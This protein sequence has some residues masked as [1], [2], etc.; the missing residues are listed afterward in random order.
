[1]RCLCP[2]GVH[3][4]TPAWYATIGKLTFVAGPLVLGNRAAW[5][6]LLAIGEGTGMMGLAA[7]HDAR[8]RAV[9]GDC[10]RGRGVDA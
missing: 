6:V 2:H 9:F 3:H 1:M 4:D 7:V 10:R 5:T 8:G